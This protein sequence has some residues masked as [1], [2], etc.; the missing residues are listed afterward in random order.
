MGTQETAEVGFD[1]RVG[2]TGYP[3]GLTA[4][5]GKSNGFSLLDLPDVIQEEDLFKQALAYLAA[6]LTSRLQRLDDPNP[7]SS[8]VSS[9][10]TMHRLSA[11]N[12]TLCWL[13]LITV[14]KIPTV[15]FTSTSASGYPT[16]FY[17]AW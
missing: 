2:R 12:R 13:R 7:V 17:R 8:H 5:K 10:P 6:F 11:L 14:F 15:Y 3:N 1:A 4:H 9:F 16:V